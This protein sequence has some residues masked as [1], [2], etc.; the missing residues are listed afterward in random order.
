MIIRRLSL[1]LLVLCAARPACAGSVQ[2]GE[3]EDWRAMKTT[4]SGRPLCYAVTQPTRRD[5]EG[6]RRGEAYLFVTHRPAESVHAEVS[7]SFGFPLSS[8]SL[9]VGGGDETTMLD[10]GSLAWL[11]NA[12]AD[13]ATVRLFKKEY[14]ATIAA[15]S[16]RGNET[17]DTYSL[18]GFSKALEAIDEACG[19]GG[20]NA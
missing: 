9:A 12:D 6:L 15:K 5:P 17:T 13:A 14:T 11:Q 3:F 10:S 2:L 18:R 4:V 20:D 8:A 19:A 7:V 16:L 1:A